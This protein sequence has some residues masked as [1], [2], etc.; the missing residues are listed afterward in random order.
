MPCRP[1]S[2][3]N[4][5]VKTKSFGL[6]AFRNGQQSST[7]SFA[8][9]IKST[10]ARPRQKI[11]FIASLDSAI[12]KLTTYEESLQVIVGAKSVTHAVLIHQF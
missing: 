12:L 5:D 4:A 8:N 11:R 7:P 2:K 6:L 3:L 10:G 9:G 1:I